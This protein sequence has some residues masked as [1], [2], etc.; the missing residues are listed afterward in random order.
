MTEQKQKFTVTFDVV[1][2]SMAH[3]I[4][5]EA[6]SEAEADAKSEELAKELEKHGDFTEKY[7]P[8]FWSDVPDNIEIKE[9]SVFDLEAMPASHDTPVGGP[10]DTSEEEGAT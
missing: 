2:Y 8:D 9:V 3:E 4:V 1:F 6:S 10:E 5:I 7:D